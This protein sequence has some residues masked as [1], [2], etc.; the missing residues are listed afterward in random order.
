MT[1]RVLDYVFHLHLVNFASPLQSDLR[2]P[3]SQGNKATLSKQTSF[4]ETSKCICKSISWGR[5]SI[6]Q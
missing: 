6:F 2:V 1:V 4:L 5:E 3:V